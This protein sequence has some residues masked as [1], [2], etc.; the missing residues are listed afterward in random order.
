[1]AT[2]FEL[3]DLSLFVSPASKMNYVT[4][5]LQAWTRGYD[6]PRHTLPATETDFVPSRMPPTPECHVE[7]R[8]S[9]T[10]GNGLFATRDIPAGSTILIKPRPLVG[11]L[12][13][14]RLQDTCH[15]CFLWAYKATKSCS[16]HG[17]QN[18]VPG[19]PGCA[20]EGQHPDIKSCAGCKKVKYCSK[21]CHLFLHLFT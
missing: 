20:E 19:C 17:S 9:P 10:A 6:V 12:D 8:A 3:T 18:Q 1:M 13:L 16:I 7:V 14:A 21:V 4:G 15:N 2:T 11:E 5:L